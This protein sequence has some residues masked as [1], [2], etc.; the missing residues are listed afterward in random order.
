VQTRTAK[1]ETLVDNYSFDGE[2]LADAEFTNHRLIYV[3]PELTSDVHI[4]G[5]PRVTV[6]MAASKARANLSVYLVSLPWESG[7][8]TVITDNLITRGWADFRNHKDIR[9]EE[10]VKPGDFV[11]VTFDLMPD[12]Q[13]IRKGQQIGLMIF[14]SDKDFTLLPQPGTELTVDLAGTKIT[15]PVVGG[16]EALEGAMK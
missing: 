10:D 13:L 2:A 8:R 11:D 3:T 9:K 6:R 7:R 16:K 12:D 14:S 1:K 5:V 4:S 15:L